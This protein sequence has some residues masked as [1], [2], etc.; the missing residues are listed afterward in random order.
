YIR[1]IQCANIFDG[2]EA[3]VPGMPGPKGDMHEQDAVVADSASTPPSAQS[4]VPWPAMWPRDSEEPKIET[5]AVVRGRREFTISAQDVSNEA[6][7]EPGL[8]TLPGVAAL[9]TGP[10]ATEPGISVIRQREPSLRS[11]LHKTLPSDD[12]GHA[13]RMPGTATH[14][15]VPQP[16]RFAWL[17]SGV[18]TVLIVAGL[19][20]LVLQLAYV[21]RLQ[22]AENAPWLRPGLERIC[23]SLDCTVPYARKPDLMVVTHSS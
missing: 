23:A 18:W 10:A 15:T 21:F 4:D 7:T 2:Y 6:D 20:A 8:H 11:D 19:L 1:C 13:R 3:V 17:I 14:A 9:P 12:A 16:D 22:L 5:P